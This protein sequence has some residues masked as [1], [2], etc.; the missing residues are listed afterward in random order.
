[1][2]NYGPLLLIGFS[3]FLLDNITVYTIGLVM[4]S[5]LN[6]I[7]KMFFQE[8]RPKIR[9]KFDKFGMPSGHTQTS[10]Y[11]TIFVFLTIKKKEWLYLYLFISLIIMVQR[12]VCNY[13]TVMQVIVGAM[14]GSIFGYFV[15]DIQGRLA[16]LNAIFLGS[17]PFLII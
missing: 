6:L 8:L 7:L 13:H 4:N 9:N 5:L 11:S 12:V 2:L 1:M 16:N 10:L 3:W 15:Y 14:V 17:Q